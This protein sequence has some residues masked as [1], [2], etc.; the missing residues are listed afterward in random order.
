MKEKKQISMKGNFLVKKYNYRK[1]IIFYLYQSELFS[2]HLD[3][4]VIVNNPLN[5]INPCEIQALQ[6]IESKYE[7]LKKIIEKFIL[8]TWEWER[9]S[10]LI[11]AILIF[12][13]YELTYNDSSV[14]IY[15]LVNITKLFSPGND[16]KFVN[17]IL[18]KISKQIINK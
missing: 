13:V 4:S 18:D 8:E 7:T 16:Y 3:T 14:V 5:E 2:V 17:K 12:G 6:I 9:I 11:R 1:N 15:E 10:P